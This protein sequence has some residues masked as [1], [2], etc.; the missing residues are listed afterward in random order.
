MVSQTTGTPTSGQKTTKRRSTLRFEM[1]SA[2]VDRAMGDLKRAE[3]A[4]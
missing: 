1:L 2:F 3:I 4:I